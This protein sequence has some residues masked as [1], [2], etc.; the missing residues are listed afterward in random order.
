M[1]NDA[2]LAHT[3]WVIRRASEK[4]PHGEFL[5]ALHAELVYRLFGAPGLGTEDLPSVNQP[6]MG[7]IGYHFRTGVHDVRPFDWKRHL[8]FAD[9]YFGPTQAASSKPKL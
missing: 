6:A 3:D 4:G 7:T 2:Y 1:P 8:D 5:S 9:R